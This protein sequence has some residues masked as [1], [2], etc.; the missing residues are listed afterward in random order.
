MVF[1]GVASTT[2]LSFGQGQTDT[3]AQTGDD[4]PDANGMDLFV[5]YGATGGK[6]IGLFTAVPEPGAGLLVL[7]AGMALL[8]AKRRRLPR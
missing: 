5:T 8:G 6:G 4:A 7:L 2:T 1:V 3:I